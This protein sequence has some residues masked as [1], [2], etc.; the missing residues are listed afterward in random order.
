MHC[1]ANVG[2]NGDVAIFFGLS[3]T[4]KT[5]LSADP[6]RSLIGDDEHGW[7][8]TG[9]FNFEGGCYAKVIRLSRE[10]EPQIYECTRRFGTIL[11]NVAIDAKTRRI[12]LDDDTLTENTRA[13]Y[14][15]GHIENALRSG[16][17]DHPRNIFMLT[18]DA[19]GV[20]P[21]IAKLTPEQAIYHFLTGYTAKVAGTERGM[22]KEP[23]A[24]FSS[25]FGAPF[26]PLPP[27]VYA[28][29]LRDRISNHKVNCW[30]VN[31]GLTGGPFGIGKRISIGHTRAIIH[32]A[33]RG[34]LH[35]VPTWQDPI[36]N[37]HIP[38]SCQGVPTEI[39]NPR[40]TWSRPN[41]YDTVA[42]DLAAKFVKNFE[43]FEP[44]VSPEV[45]MAG[46]RR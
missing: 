35:N 13:G 10:A 39:L 36:F 20:L 29:L 28:K 32:T 30:L 24:T 38:V 45:R 2:P 27:A 1:S 46:P 22:G 7:S 34:D 43:Q 26:L 9:V 14:P 3:G 42:S 40:N 25:C 19:F 4:G 15:L 41:E 37:L 12:D 11:E 44:H 31:T 8:E 18:Y 6:E 5:T 21:P 23:Q 17:G 33:L 16:L